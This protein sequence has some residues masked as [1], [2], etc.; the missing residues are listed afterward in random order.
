MVS[1][2]PA[3]AT[4]DLGMDGVVLQAERVEEVVVRNVPDVV[5]Q[6]ATDGIASVCEW[7]EVGAEDGSV[8]VLEE[9]VDK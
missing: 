8:V 5:R 3:F 6:K 2:A 4:P 7:R 9:F 1:D